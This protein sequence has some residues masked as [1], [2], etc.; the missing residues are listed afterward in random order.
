[1]S[2][3]WGCA[4]AM[5]HIREKQQRRRRECPAVRHR[6]RNRE[7]DRLDADIPLIDPDQFKPR[8]ERGCYPV[9]HSSQDMAPDVVRVP[10]LK[11]ALGC[12]AGRQGQWLYQQQSRDS[13]PFT[14]Q[15]TTARHT[16]CCCVV[17]GAATGSGAKSLTRPKPDR[18]A[19]SNFG[20]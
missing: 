17:M 12:V 2:V 7:A 16:A 20:P 5:N 11:P 19:S 13:N 6:G 4:H 8:H 14:Y 18:A 15:A 1:M 9:R 3:S 10:A